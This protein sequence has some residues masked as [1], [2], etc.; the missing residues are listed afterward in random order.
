M[1][2]PRAWLVAFLGALSVHCVTGIPTMANDHAGRCQA[3]MD[4]FENARCGNV[5]PTASALPTVEAEYRQYAEC[6]DPVSQERLKKLETSCVARYREA[7]ATATNEHDEIRKKYDKQVGE[8]KADPT[9]MPKLEKWALARDEAQIAEN[10]W[11]VK[12]GKQSSSPYFRVYESK[13][14]ALEKLNADMRALI[15]KHGI[16]PKYSSVLGI[17]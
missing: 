6:T 8:L 16:D 7:K 3:G 17:W 5:T 4:M 13:Q 14:K 9:Y 12:G 10:D 11:V 1:S 2:S 15:S